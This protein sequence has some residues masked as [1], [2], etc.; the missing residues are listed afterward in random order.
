VQSEPQLGKRFLFSLLDALALPF[1]SAAAVVLKAARRVSLHRLPLCRSMLLRIGVI[2][3]RRHYYEPFLDPAELARP[4]EQ[5][6]P[7]PGVDWR[8]ERQLAQLEEFRYGHELHDLRAPRSNSLEFRL[9]NGS[10]ESG[11]AEYLYQIVRA[12]KPSRI[13]EIGSGNSTLIV[14]RAIAKTTEEDKDYR[15]MH[16]CIEPFEAPWLEQSGA[17]VVRQRVE[18]VDRSL[19]RELRANDLLFIDS[20]HVI[21]P[22]GDVLVEYL[23]I[24]PLLQPGVIVHIHDIF[25]PRDYP[26]EWVIDRLRMWN[27]QYLVEAFLTQNESWQVIGALNLL[28]H[29]HFEALKRVCPYLTPDREPGSLYIQKVK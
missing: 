28:H 5:D 29:S 7:L 17:A 3:L 24:L 22:Q 14:R 9:D 11:D 16:L 27:E 10:F 23:E 26:R 12:K 18:E 6:R 21:R 19:F 4:L 15:C 13:V 25:S 2:P 8:V 20:S 1:V